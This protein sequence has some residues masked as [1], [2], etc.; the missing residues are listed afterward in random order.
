MPTETGSHDAD[1]PSNAKAL[2]AFLEEEISTP[3]LGRMG[4]IANLKE[5]SYGLDVTSVRHQKQ[6][7]AGM[8][9]CRLY[10]VCI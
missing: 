10:A 7:H 5:A 1:R 3:S 6:N 9:R 8:F 4:V 2:E